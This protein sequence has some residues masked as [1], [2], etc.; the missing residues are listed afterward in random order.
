VEEEGK[1]KEENKN[2]LFLTRDSQMQYEKHSSLQNH[3]NNLRHTNFSPFCAKLKKLQKG[4]E[5]KSKLSMSSKLKFEIIIQFERRNW[6]SDA[7]LR[8]NFFKKGTNEG[9]RIPFSFLRLQFANKRISV[10]ILVVFGVQEKTNLVSCTNFAFCGHNG[11]LNVKGMMILGEGCG[12]PKA[13]S[14]G[15]AGLVVFLD[16]RIS[17]E[18]EVRVCAKESVIKRVE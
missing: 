10:V 17:W 16:L 7:N 1:F 18:W 15:C 13:N 14:C 3:E 4:Q 8:G 12:F 5:K 11:K 2:H 9:D 6:S